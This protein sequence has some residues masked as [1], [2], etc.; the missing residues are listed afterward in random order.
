MNVCIRGKLY[1][2]DGLLL[3]LQTLKG[4][5]MHREGWE[6]SGVVVPLACG[7]LSSTC[8]QLASYPLSL[9]RTRLQAQGTCVW[10]GEGRMCV[11]APY[12]CVCWYNTV[13][14]LL[15]SSQLALL[16]MKALAL[17]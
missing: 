6:N 11:C 5:W 14:F 16:Q 9:V 7:T 15:Y 4:M 3:L 12:V 1:H 2:L 8:G 17:A 13:H 10:G